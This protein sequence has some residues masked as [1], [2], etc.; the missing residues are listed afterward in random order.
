MTDYYKI[1]GVSPNATSEEIKKSYRQL[2]LKYHPDKNPGSN[3]AENF[4]KQITEAYNIL[5]SIEKREAYDR[6]YNKSSKQQ[7]ENEG[8]QESKITPDVILEIFK[9]IRIKLNGIDKSRINQVKLYNSINDLLSANIIS[10]LKLNNDYFTNKEIINEALSCCK[11]LDYSYVNQLSPK[12]I[13]IAG[14]DNESIQKIYSFNKKQKSRNNWEVLKIFIPIIAILLFIAIGPNLNCSSNT[15]SSNNRPDGDLNNSFIDSS[16]NKAVEIINDNTSNTENN[17]KETHQENNNLTSEQILQQEKEKLINDGWEETTINNGQLPSCYNFKPKRSN[18]DNYLEVH[19]G[20]GTD[21][22]IKV[23]NVE[24]DECIRYVFINSGSTYKIRNIPE[25][26]YYLKIA[27]GKNW[28]SKIEGDQCVGKFI[29][30][31][32]YEKGEDIM[33]FNLDHTSD[34]YNI[35]SFQLKLDVISTNTM[36]T[37]SSKNISESD[38][39]Q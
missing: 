16:V 14:S 34:G 32:L 6:K 19:V 23:M 33:D 2:A 24:T 30:N 7:K 29:Q 20:G 10:L 12:L 18:I 38:F 37:F 27:Y 21:V 39:N 22:V 26:K 13:E 31:P 3:V 28:F 25:G 36:S 1:L 17:L 11:S 15:F 35:P 9:E 4:F 5:S 8:N